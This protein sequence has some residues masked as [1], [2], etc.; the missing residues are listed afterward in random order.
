MS[1]IKKLVLALLLGLLIGGQSL[2]ATQDFKGTINSVNPQSAAVGFTV[3]GGT[4]SKILTVDET[5][6]M[7][8]KSPLFRVSKLVIVG[9][10]DATQVNLT[11]S[12][13]WNGENLSVETVD[14][15]TPTGGTRF[16]ISAGGTNVTIKG[17]TKTPT[18]FISASVFYNT[19]GTYYTAYP[20]SI[21]A[22]KLVLKLYDVS[23]AA[24][25]L[26]GIANGKEIYI[27]LTYATSD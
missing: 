19:T 23:G 21:T 18:T 4:T 13:I 1:V 11:L 22:N 9:L 26:C 24:L 27:M 10:T 3:A 7:S 5:T 15:D 25:D 14:K 2:A 16:D 8:M 17:M 20:L 12:S 6:T